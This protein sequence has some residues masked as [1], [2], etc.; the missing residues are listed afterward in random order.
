MTAVV[1]GFD[2]PEEL[3]KVISD[4][5]WTAYTEE[6]RLPPGTVEAVF[7]EAP[8]KTWKFYTLD[9]MRSISME[10]HDED[11]PLWFGVPPDDIDA[12]QSVLIGELG[13]DR[14][15]ALD[16]RGTRSVVRFMTVEGRWVQVAESAAS[17]LDALG[18]EPGD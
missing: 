5:S 15:F 14:P 8:D 7:G 4:E 11:D 9:E 17:L 12:T 18:I 13:Y 10:W 2:L 16:F 3:V 1:C 6:D